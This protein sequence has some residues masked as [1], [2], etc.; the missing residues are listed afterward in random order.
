MLATTGASWP[1]WSQDG[2]YIYFSDFKALLRLRIDDRQIEQL[3]AFK[4]LRLAAGYTGTW[5]GWAPDDSPLVLRDTGIQ[6]IYAL[7]WQ[8]P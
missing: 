4:D 2:K 5:I 3:A 1:H 7:E 6:D 8:T